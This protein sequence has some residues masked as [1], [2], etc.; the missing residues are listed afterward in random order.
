M[1]GVI[2]PRRHAAGWALPSLPRPPSSRHAAAAAR[3]A[4]A[5]ASR[6]P[7][8]LAGGAPPPFLIDAYSGLLSPHDMSAKSWSTRHR[9]VYCLA[10]AAGR[11]LEELKEEQLLVELCRVGIAYDT[12]YEKSG[13][14]FTLAMPTL[15]LEIS[16]D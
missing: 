10:A 16:K 14:F 5:T 12:R 6:T 7:G 15:C 2:K 3:S 11:M 9:S 13:T 8:A 1:S 4:A